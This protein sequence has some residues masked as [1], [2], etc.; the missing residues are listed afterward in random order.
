[1]S[2]DKVAVP[3]NTHENPLLQKLTPKQFDASVKFYEADHQLS[4]EDRQV[5]AEDLQNVVFSTAFYGYGAGVSSF[6]I[7]TAYYT[8]TQ[9][10]SATVR[11]SAPV[12]RGFFKKPFL[13]FLIG[14]TAMMV[15]NQQVCK[16]KF[17]RKIQE[18]DQTSSHRAAVWKS[19]DYHQASLFYLYY[20]KTA[21]NPDFIVQDP[22]KVDSQSLHKVHYEPSKDEHFTSTLGMK[23]DEGL[24]HWDQIRLANGFGVSKEEGGSREE[25]GSKWNDIR[26]G[27][28]DESENRGN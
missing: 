6:M 26:Q 27:I 17:N 8:L 13:S 3:T 18:E 25:G 14:V 11:R 5:I 28:K 9:G 19:M 12:P 10:N 20:R 15:T 23:N 2:D 1:M 16:Y 7:P 24:S 4:H 21:E 22:R